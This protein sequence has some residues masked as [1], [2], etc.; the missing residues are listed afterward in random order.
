MARTFAQAAPVIQM[1][2]DS[3]GTW[4]DMSAYWLRSAGLTFK[5]GRTSEFASLQAGQIT[6]TL[7]NNDCRF[8]PGRQILK[9]LVT[10]AP[11]YPS[12]FIGLRVRYLWTDELG[13]QQLRM[14]GSVTS[15]T[16]DAVSQTVT[17]TAADDLARLQRKIL[18]APIVEECLA[19]L[20]TVFFGLQES[21]TATSGVDAIGGL[22][23]TPT[24]G[25]SLSPI[26]TTTATVLWGQPLPTPSK[27]LGVD[28]TLMDPGSITCVQCTPSA[29]ETAGL[30]LGAPLA[31]GSFPWE[32]FASCDDF[33][34]I[35][36]KYFW[37]VQDWSLIG[38]GAGWGV[39]CNV[40]SPGIMSWTLRQYDS[41]N[42]TLNTITTSNVVA[43]NMLHQ[44]SVFITNVAGVLKLNLSIDAEQI[45]GIVQN[46]LYNGLLAFSGPWRMFASANS[47]AGNVCRFLAA[48]QLRGSL[49]APPLSDQRI[50]RYRSLML[51]SIY[52]FP[53]AH[54]T[55]GNIIR[56]VFGRNTVSI[57]SSVAINIG[58]IPFK[59]LSALSAI[60]NIL[61]TVGGGASI[62]ALNGGGNFL[63]T[64]A[65]FRRRLK[66]DI[67]IDADGDIMG[68]TF[69]PALDASPPGGSV[70]TNTGL[71][72][73]TGIYVAGD[74]T[75]PNPDS[76]STYIASRQYTFLYPVRGNDPI[77]PLNLAQYRIHSGR[78][79][80]RVPQLRVSFLNSQT[81]NLN[82]SIAVIIGYGMLPLGS[83][84]RVICT[85]DKFVLPVKQFDVFIEGWTEVMNTN[86]WYITFDTSSAGVP[87]FGI[88]SDTNVQ[89]RWT[90]DL[91]SITLNANIT[92]S[93]ASLVAATLVG[94]P[95]FT[96]AGG[97][98]PF[99]IKVGAEI[100]TVTAV[101]GP[102]TPQTLT[103]TRGQDGTFAAAQTA[104]A[105]ITLAP[106][107]TW[108]L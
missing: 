67:T 106:N 64:D 14:D 63:Y 107:M 22:R 41:A 103:I 30:T 86:D 79:E 18:Q 58:T 62:R 52:T 16:P 37:K 70:V 7:D 48:G 49:Y 77:A 89:T 42:V 38:G 15:W 26:A 68:D 10:P 32:I 94:H 91:N 47:V 78:S 74:P 81:A 40:T 33:T 1:S 35:G 2:F 71:G 76:A 82:A 69:A 61:D 50:E 96:V 66:I 46:N 9:D 4:V 3:G 25:A 72:G 97:S 95:A 87:E 105:V 101:S 6:F 31:G 27:G 39:T 80:Y 45:I 8:I 5:M 55:I 73:A 108:G 90:P 85:S 93:A 54:R 23:A 51:S 28:G 83:R 104:G 99:K 12:T 36:A 84:M 20:P 102:T 100:M 19:A 98:I 43:D 53:T 17:V 60:Q 88:W 21:S 11:Y 56:Y 34:T 57:V 13:V 59:G 92:A 44:I 65:L 75:L 24:F 29:T